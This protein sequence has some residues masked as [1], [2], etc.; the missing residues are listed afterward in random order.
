MARDALTVE[1]DVCVAWWLR[2]YLTAAVLLDRI[3]CAIDFDRVGRAVDRAVT[4]SIGGSRPRH[5][6][7]NTLA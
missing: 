2:P 4:F 5:V 3:G 7:S 1:I 6:F